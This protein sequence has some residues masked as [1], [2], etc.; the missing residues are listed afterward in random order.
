MANKTEQSRKAY[1]IKALN[2]ENTFD[3]KFTNSFKNK[4]IEI[5]AVKAGDRL[6]DVACGTGSLINELSLKADVTAFGIDISEKMIKTA[7]AKYNGIDF[8]I[9]SCVPLKFANKTLDVITVSAAFHHF[10]A[11]MKFAE[12][13]YRVLGVDGTIYIAEVNMNPF[14]RSLIN[15][16]IP[17]MRSGDVK[18]YSEKELKFFF[19][20]AGFSDIETEVDGKIIFLIGKKKG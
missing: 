20:M 10:D 19:E 6:L 7:K 13:A 5:I 18:I 15:L 14:I 17:L 3:G 9:S 2:Y 11:P 1:N 8:D 12:E 16:C 4:F